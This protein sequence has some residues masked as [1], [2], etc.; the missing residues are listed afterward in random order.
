MKEM[1]VNEIYE[2]IMSDVCSAGNVVKTS[3][4]SVGVTVGSIAARQFTGSTSLQTSCNVTT[5]KLVNQSATFTRDD[6]D[7]D[8]E[9]MPFCKLHYLLL[10]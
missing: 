3:G 10:F 7:D 5:P 2:N 1:L 4:S 9:P 6:L 8:F